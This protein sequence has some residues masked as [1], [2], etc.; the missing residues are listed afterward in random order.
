MR[1]RSVFL[2][3]LAVLFLV[4]G[5]TSYAAKSKKPEPVTIYNKSA[6]DI[7]AIYVSAHEKEDY[8][9]NLI[10][11]GRKLP[12]GGRLKAQIKGDFSKFD[13]RIESYD[14]YEDYFGFPANAVT[15]ELYGGGRSKFTEPLPEEMQ[16]PK[17]IPL[18]V[19]PQIIPLNQTVQTTS[20][21]Q[22]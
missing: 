20:L 1:I 19:Q 10:P 12:S 9:I 5:S 4:T 15:V 7:T 8:C 17:I 11:N 14:A 13:L 21:F 22:R 18:P 3:S 16:N 2:S 6:S